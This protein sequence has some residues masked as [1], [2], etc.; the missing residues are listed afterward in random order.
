MVH[1]T[2]LNREQQRW[3]VALPD[4]Y[5]Y[6]AR[7]VH[8]VYNCSRGFLPINDH[9]FKCKANGWRAYGSQDASLKCYSM[10]IKYSLFPSVVESNFEL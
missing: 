5:G 6:Y 10:Y 9:W 4:T 1:Y 2:Q 3:D 8:A 7:D